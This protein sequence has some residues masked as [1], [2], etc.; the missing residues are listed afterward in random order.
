VIH[1][2]VF[3]L[4]FERA[5]TVVP[6]VSESRGSFA[7]LESPVESP[8]S[9]AWSSKGSCQYDEITEL[10]RPASEPGDTSQLL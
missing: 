4:G 6:D 5:T 1:R 3:G 2:D 8:F 9:N 10:A 7:P